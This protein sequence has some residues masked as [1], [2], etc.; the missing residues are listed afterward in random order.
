MDKTTKL[1]IAIVVLAG[2]MFWG[3]QSGTFAKIF[4]GPVQPI[5]IPEGIILFYGEECPHCKIVDE[6]VAE[7]NVKE[8]VNFSNLEVWRSKDNQAILGQVVKECK[9]NSSEVGVPFLYDG[10]GNC[11]VGDV[12]VINFFKNA[13]G[14]Q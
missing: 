11:Y 1:T 2:F 14:I 13:S 9:I 5:E 12:D 10:S 4:S 7:N 8:K 6:F 3:F